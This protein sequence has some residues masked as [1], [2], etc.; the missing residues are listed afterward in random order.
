VAV[1][2]KEDLRSFFRPTKKEGE[3]R[4]FL[5][6]FLALGVGCSGGPW[7]E[8]PVIVVCEDADGDGAG[9]LW[10][11]KQVR[12]WDAPEGFVEIEAADDCND[13]DPAVNPKAQNCEAAQKIPFAE[14]P[15]YKSID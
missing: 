2:E 9:D 5:L 14:R 13:A 7:A 4:V 10:D 1:R 15:V 11:C 3:M 12:G 8:G 6:V